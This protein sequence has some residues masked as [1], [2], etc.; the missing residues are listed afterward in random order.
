MAADRDDPQRFLPPHRGRE[1]VLE[2]L[3][4]PP[5]SHRVES[6]VPGHAPGREGAPATRLFLARPKGQAPAAGHPLLVMLDGNAAFD[7]LTRDLLEAMPGLAVA[8]VGYDTDKQFAREQRIFDLS[9]PVAPGAEPRPDPHHPGR[10]A[11]GGEAFLD[12]LTGPLMAEITARCPVDPAR[13]T[14]WGHSFGGLF[15]L[16]AAATRPGSFAR[17]ASISPSVWWDEPLARRLT[18]GARFDPDAPTRMYLAL[19]D[20]EKRTGSDGPPPD[21]PAP[22]TMALADLLRDKP[23]LRLETEVYPGAVHIAT[24]PA[25]L[26]A[27]LRLAA[28]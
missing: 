20:R 18:E 23:G 4:N 25:S 16:Y 27:T 24:L 19:G 10:M 22:A 13:R 8:G 14:L 26:P 9:P 6:W 15:T 3:Q 7:F 28:E 2:I 17:Y 12:R 11:G 21:G 5:A 1:A